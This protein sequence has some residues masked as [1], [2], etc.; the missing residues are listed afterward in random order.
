MKAVNK[1]H[2]SDPYR[3]SF[4]LVNVEWAWDEAFRPFCELDKTLWPVIRDGTALSTGK[5]VIYCLR[6]KKSVR[7]SWSHYYS[8]NAVQLVFLRSAILPRKI[9]RLFVYPTFNLKLENFYVRVSRLTHIVVLGILRQV[10][11]SK[12]PQDRVS[13]CNYA[14]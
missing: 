6:S 2:F 1:S 9:H 14:M 10:V 5:K 8:S 11:P 4:V 12:R 3:V 13:K 7:I